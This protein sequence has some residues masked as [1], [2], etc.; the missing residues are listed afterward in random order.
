[1]KAAPPARSKEESS[2]FSGQAALGISDA[3]FLPRRSLLTVIFCDFVL[4][5][6]LKCVYG[7]IPF[8]AFPS[9]SLNSDVL[10]EEDGDSPFS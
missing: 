9:P 5:D 8:A 7:G 10:F 1:M 3:R 6:R 4:H 2:P